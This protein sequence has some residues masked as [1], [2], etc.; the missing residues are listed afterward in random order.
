M[1]K[2]I[3]AIV[4]IILMAAA[5]CT[6]K[7]NGV[8]VIH[9]PVEWD[10]SSYIPRPMNDSLIETRFL[11]STGEET[12]T[13]TT[14]AS[15][16]YELTYTEVY[17]SGIV[18]SVRMIFITDAG[19]IIDPI[20]NEEVVDKIQVLH[21]PVKYDSS[22]YIPRPMNDSL[23]ET[24]FLW[25]TGE[26]TPTITTSLPGE[27]QFTYSKVYVS[28]IT[29]SVTQTF[30]VTDSVTVIDPV[31]NVYYLWS[32]GETTSSIKIIEPG[33][34]VREEVYIYASGVHSNRS[35]TFK[36]RDNLEYEVVYCPPFEYNP[37]DMSYEVIEWDLSTCEIIPIDSVFGTVYSYSMF[38]SGYLIKGEICK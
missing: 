29:S 26:E 24:R 2:S 21:N 38:D 18:S 30:I 14:P 35:I 6:N 25:S 32:T 17:S 15:G 31:I 1:K 28:G 4:A 34:Y 19:M 13:I 12:K 8:K 10:S 9:Y 7:T 16:E 3:I 37:G 5:S 27:Y 23:I 33:N 22:S 36:L 20:V 11:W